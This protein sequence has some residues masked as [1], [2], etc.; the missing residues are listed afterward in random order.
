MGDIVDHLLERGDVKIYGFD[1]TTQERRGRENSGRSDPLFSTDEKNANLA[2]P[3]SLKRSLRSVFGR[4]DAVLT[5]K[6]RTRAW[7]FLFHTFFR[8]TAVC[9]RTEKKN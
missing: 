2:Q 8:I 3:S 5:K 1:A 6:P 9:P 4:F 7:L